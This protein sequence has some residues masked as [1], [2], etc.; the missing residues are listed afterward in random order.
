[1]SQGQLRQQFPVS[2][3]VFD[4]RVETQGETVWVDLDGN[5]IE[6]AVTTQNAQEGWC[7][8]SDGNRHSFFWTWTGNAL[9]LWVDGNLSIFEKVESRRQVNRVA[10]GRDSDIVAPMPGKVGQLLVQP[11]DS[12]ERGQT[13]IIVESM[14]ME[15]E[16]AAQRDGVVKRVLVEPGAQVDKGMR[17]LEL[18]EHHEATG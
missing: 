4:Y 8:T 7:R 2:D 15:L 11:G 13:V 6:L 5:E 3:Q 12:V 9:H 1:V 14:K 10:S 17:L 16:I 18:E